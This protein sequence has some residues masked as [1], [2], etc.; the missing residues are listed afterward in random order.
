MLGSSSGGNIL[1]FAI[2]EERCLVI[3]SQIHP[4]VT[5]I[6]EEETREPLNQLT[7]KIILSHFSTKRFII[8]CFVAP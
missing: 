6:T 8:T 1:V 5:S 4:M 7:L 2:L 3:R